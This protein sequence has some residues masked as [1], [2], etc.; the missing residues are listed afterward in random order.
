MPRAVNCVGTIITVFVPTIHVA[1]PMLAPS[2]KPGDI[3][4]L[5]I[6]TVCHSTLL[7]QHI[8]LR[9]AHPLSLRRAYWDQQLT[10]DSDRSFIWDGIC[11]GFLIVKPDVKANPASCKNHKSVLNVDNKARVES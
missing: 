11:N 5:L 4:S 6:R 10:E 1:S 3:P 7:L 8:V 9:L 2:A